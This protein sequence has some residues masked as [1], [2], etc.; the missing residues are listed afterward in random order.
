[1]LLTERKG[2]L[3]KDAEEGAALAHCISEDCRMGKGI[4]AIFKKNYGGVSELLKQVRDGKKTGTAAVLRRD[5]RLVFYLITKR[6]YSD[7]PTYESLESS[8]MDMKNELLTAG[9]TKLAI[10]KLGCGLDGLNWHQVKAIIERVFE[11][12]DVDVVVYLL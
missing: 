2:D 11:D 8:L 6:I 9:V 10:P 12:T 7:K 3:F 5:E 4:A 1:M